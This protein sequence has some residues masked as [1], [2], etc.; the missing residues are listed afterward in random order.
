MLSDKK[1][2]GVKGEG[3]RKKEFAYNIFVYWNVKILDKKAVTILQVRN[4]G[5]LNKDG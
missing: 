1:I 2:S 4:I 3:K 5:S